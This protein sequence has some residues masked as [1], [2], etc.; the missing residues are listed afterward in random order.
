MI[1][2][3]GSPK[4]SEQFTKGSNILKGEFKD[5]TQPVVQS[6]IHSHLKNFLHILRDPKQGIQRERHIR[7]KFL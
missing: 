6:F 1:V 3:S 7:L 5:S 2:R 4:G